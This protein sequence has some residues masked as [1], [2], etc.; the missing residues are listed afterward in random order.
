VD[1]YLND[2]PSA[3]LAGTDVATSSW[4]SSDVL[5]QL[6]LG[7]DDT[8]LYIGIA[9]SA[10][11]QNAIVGYLNVSGLAWGSSSIA[12]T[13]SD[14]STPGD[15][16][17]ELSSVF[18]V[19]DTTFLAQYGYGL[20]GSAPNLNNGI[21]AGIGVRQLMNGADLAWATATVARTSGA[22]EFAIPWQTSGNGTDLFVPFPSGNNNPLTIRAFARLVAC[23][24]SCFATQ[25]LPDDPNLLPSVTSPM[26]QETV[27]EVASLEVR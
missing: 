26:T 3:A 18:T 17:D 20:F 21:G 7:Y 9:G 14:H 19:A 27:S 25:G 10:E 2:W 15:L 11:P 12:T 6:Y 5:T 8:N 1:G 4:G 22:V 24:G 13:L 23:G 16:D